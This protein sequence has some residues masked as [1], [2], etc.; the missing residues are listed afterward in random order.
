MA[1]VCTAGSPRPPGTANQVFWSASEAVGVAEGCGEFFGRD[2]QLNT[3]ADRRRAAHGVMAGPHPRGAADYE[4]ALLNE[5]T[6]K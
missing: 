1:Q 4:A 3:P 5:L 6:E 2:A